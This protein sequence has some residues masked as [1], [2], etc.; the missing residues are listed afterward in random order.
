MVQCAL[1]M[2]ETLGSMPRIKE[3]KRE[4]KRRDEERRT[5]ERRAKER[6]GEGRGERYNEK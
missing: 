2:H 3:G 5:E 4:E 1:S 6:R